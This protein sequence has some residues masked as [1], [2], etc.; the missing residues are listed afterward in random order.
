MNPNG[1]DF[2]LHI[3]MKRLITL[4][5]INLYS[6]SMC[7]KVPFIDFVKK[8]VMHQIDI[9]FIF[10]II[11]FEIFWYLKIRPLHH[12]LPTHNINLPS[13]QPSSTTVPLTTALGYHFRYHIISLEFLD[14]II[15]YNNIFI[16]CVF[17]GIGFLRRKISDFHSNYFKISFRYLSK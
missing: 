10:N 8:C 6:C 13:T 12:I 4:C 16:S 15:F 1:N 9:C 17:M 11:W 3:E 2:F 14:S 7:S 5:K